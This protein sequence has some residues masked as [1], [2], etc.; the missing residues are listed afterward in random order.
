MRD[1]KEVLSETKERMDECLAYWYTCDKNGGL[2]IKK[3]N[4]EDLGCL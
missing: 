2:L 3:M 4:T 1:R